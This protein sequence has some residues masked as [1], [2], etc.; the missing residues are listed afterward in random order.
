[1]PRLHG[2]AAGAYKVTGDRRGAPNVPRVA[3][4]S[5]NS[6]LGK[7]VAGHLGLCPLGCRRAEG[8]RQRK[9]RAMAFR[10]PR[11]A[12]GNIKIA[13]GNKA[14]LASAGLTGLSSKARGHHARAYSP[15]PRPAAQERLY[16]FRQ[17]A[18]TY[19]KSQNILSHENSGKTPQSAS[20]ATAPACG[21]SQKYPTTPY[22]SVCINT[23][24]GPTA[25][26]PAGGRPDQGW[27]TLATGIRL[28]QRGWKDSPPPQPA[29]AG[30]AAG[31]L[32]PSLFCRCL[33]RRDT[34]AVGALLA[35][36]AS[37]T[38]SQHSAVEPYATPS[39]CQRVAVSV[40]AGRRRDGCAALSA[41]FRPPG[42][43]AQAGRWSPRCWC[44]SMLCCEQYYLTWFA[45]T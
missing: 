33:Q 21:K 17:S 32:F 15:G 35:A 34:V 10:P 23:R 30:V 14:F 28:K 3:E 40:V 9:R 27:S 44:G 8:H 13:W 38:S 1:M 36:A 6:K 31:F 37:G 11:W 45:V 20:P 41:A 5:K 42:D 7:R 12:R 25:E 39:G 24:V 26:A 4:R 18:P 16:R 22:R 29:L 2:E 43:I 19:L